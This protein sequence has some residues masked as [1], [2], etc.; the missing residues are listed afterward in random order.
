M[1]KVDLTYRSP[2][3]QKPGDLTGFGFG[4]VRT[5][6]VSSRKITFLTRAA[7]LEPSDSERSGLNPE[8]SFIDGKSSSSARASPMPQMALQKFQAQ[9]ID[10]IHTPKRV[11]WAEQSDV[12]AATTD[13]ALSTKPLGSGLARASKSVAASAMAVSIKS[14]TH[15]SSQASFIQQSATSFATQSQVE[16]SSSSSSE[17]K[18]STSS[19]QVSKVSK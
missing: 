5:G 14:E 2:G 13:F 6:Q 19:F 1:E 15:S 3:D 17:L 4:N 7:S 11:Q 10:D 18:S 16:F 9:T 12:I 8:V